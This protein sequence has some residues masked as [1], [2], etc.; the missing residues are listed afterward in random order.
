[1]ATEALARHTQYVLHYPEAAL[2]SDDNE[3]DE[4]VKRDAS[5]WNRIED[6]QQVQASVDVK[7]TFRT[8]QELL[9]SQVTID[10]IPHERKPIAPSA[11]VKTETVSHAATMSMRDQMSGH[12]LAVQEAMR[13][14]GALRV[15][16]VFNDECGEINTFSVLPNLGVLMIIMS[17]IFTLF[18]VDVAGDQVGYSEVYWA[19]IAMFT[20]PVVLYASRYARLVLDRVN[21]AGKRVIGDIVMNTPSLSTTNEVVI[22]KNPII[23]ESEQEIDKKL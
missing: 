15:L 22:S 17:I 20:F 4:G 5:L 1:L 3:D 23:N 19:P 8:A 16:K 21:V 6:I 14:W 7:T 2:D 13:P 10:P 18:I 9:E 12:E 11:E